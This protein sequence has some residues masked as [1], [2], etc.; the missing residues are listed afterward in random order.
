MSTVTQ[1]DM[2]SG[3]P[4]YSPRRRR[5]KILVES[6]SG[7]RAPKGKHPYRIYYQRCVRGKILTSVVAICSSE[8]YPCCQLLTERNQVG[9]DA[10]HAM[11]GSGIPRR[12]EQPVRKHDRDPTDRDCPDAAMALP[13]IR[14][15]SLWPKRKAPSVDERGFTDARKRASRGTHCSV[16]LLQDVLHVMHLLRALH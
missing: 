11:L 16:S 8:E 9:G 1:H 13:L 7:P 6:R 3:N 5:E 2:E 14:H 12:A 15:L 10:S 4:H